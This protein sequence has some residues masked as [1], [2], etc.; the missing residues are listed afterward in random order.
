MSDFKRRF[1]RRNCGRSHNQYRTPN[2]RTDGTEVGTVDYRIAQCLDTIHTILPKTP[3]G[4]L[5]MRAGPKARLVMFGLQFPIHIIIDQDTRPEKR[6]SCPSSGRMRT[7][8]NVGD[9]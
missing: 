9:A 2:V 4:S 5:E 1:F 8:G 7:D 6:V 3:A